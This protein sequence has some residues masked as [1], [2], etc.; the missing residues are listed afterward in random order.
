MQYEML[1][2]VFRMGLEHK[3]ANGICF[4]A[5]LQDL[6]DPPLGVWPENNSDL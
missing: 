1:D 2:R 3:E 5:F 4:L 6:H